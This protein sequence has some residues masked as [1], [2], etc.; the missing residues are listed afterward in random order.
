MFRNQ[1]L[2]AKCAHCYGGIITSRT[3][4][5]TLRGLYIYI[6]IH[7]LYFSIHP[8]HL[9]IYKNRVHTHTSNS[10][11]TP[12]RHSS[13]PYTHVSLLPNSEKPGSHFL[14]TFTHLLNPN[15][16]KKGFQNYYPLPLRIAH[17]LTKI[18]YLFSAHFDSTYTKIVKI[19]ISMQG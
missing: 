5:H 10:N 19:E 4:K 11:P 1:D 12:Q 15:K 8:I 18:R 13:C 17:I 9:C 6:R 16:R 3:S 2:N 7:T 14:N